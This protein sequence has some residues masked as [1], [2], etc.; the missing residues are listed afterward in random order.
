M[1]IY[2][3]IVGFTQIDDPRNAGLL[4]DA[5]ALG[6]NQLKLI[7]CKNI[8]FIEGQL[9][10]ETCK[11]LAL[12]LLIDPV[13][14]SC[15]WAELPCMQQE[16][17]PGIVMVEVALRPGVT[18]PVADEIV[19]ASHELGF[20]QVKRAASGYRYLVQGV[21]ETTARQ[22]TQRLLA[23][24]VIHRWTIGEIEPAFPGVTISSGD[25]EILRMRCADTEL[26]A[27]SKDRRA[28]LDLA[29][30]Q[31]IR[32]FCEEAKR[33][34][35]DIEF[36]T[37]AQTWSEHCGHKTFKG[38]ISVDRGDGNSIMIDSL[39]KTFIRSATEEINADWVLSAFVDNAGIIELDGENEIS[40]KVETHNHPSAIEPFGGANTGVGGVIRDVMGVSHKPIANTD[41]LCFGMQE[42]SFD[43]LPEGVLHPRRIMTGVVA[44]VQDYGNKMGIPTVNG[45]ILFDPGYA[46]NPLVFC[47]TLGMAP[48]RLHGRTPQVGDRVIVLGGRTG[49]DG[50]RGATFSSMTMDAQT[51]E[52]SGSSVQIGNPIIE[53]G[54]VDA[55]LPARDLGLYTAITDCG[56][57]GLSSAVGEMAATI[58]ADV[59][60]LNVRLKYPG[61]APWEIWLSE[62]QERMVLAVPPAN[63]TKLL[64]LC[65]TYNVE[66]TDIGFFSGSKRLVVRYNQKVVLDLPNA[67]LHDGIPQRELMAKVENRAERAENPIQAQ[68]PSVEPAE[69]LLKLLAHPNI[70]SK[71]GV[72]RLYDHE[73]QG[74]T[75]VKPLTGAQNDGPADAS[76]LKPAGVRGQAGIAIACGINPEFGKID[77]YRMAMAVVDEAVRNCVAAGADPERI[78]ILDNFCWGDP[79]H[80]ETLGGLVEACRGCRDAA[81]LFRTPFIS[82]KDSL[83]NEYLGADGN[84]HAIPP[85]LLISSVGVIRDVNQAM[86]MD[87]KSAG[88]IIYLVGNFRPVLGG[89]HFDLVTGQV[90]EEAVPKVDPNSARLYQCL[91]QAITDKRVHACHDLSEG[92]L[93]VSAAEMCMAGRLGLMIKLPE[94]ETLHCLFGETTGCLLVEVEPE[95]AAAFESALAGLPIQE[96]GRVTEGT[97]L[98][99]LDQGKSLIELPIDE[100]LA[101]WTK[102]LQPVQKP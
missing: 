30:M 3:T 19:R 60:L 89:S 10:L 63:L 39:Y 51:G 72:I 17:E 22:L 70:A 71:A 45:A 78:A 50:L 76:V 47:G 13:T 56:A 85:T 93:G 31:A 34:L 2:R 57:G 16:M 41:V 52:V 100:L 97:S 46:A 12:S 36:E 18:D 98:Q 75:V 6:F 53:K 48:K 83:N 38:K 21:D 74:G 27:I 69:I 43:E 23:N 77:T 86:T 58:G 1:P 54:L 84:R 64:E 68:M 81:L 65:D 102:P 87:L 42:T 25:V 79:L 61:L 28:A 7:Q 33:D 88:N 15:E 99:I 49:R 8:Y 5:L 59:D 62:A 29:E 24:M 90:S 11:Q 55:L 66:L 73:V 82:G 26:Q 96:L 95:Q 9:S 4:A 80:P 35:S 20:L 44:G 101:A 67:F 32:A 91:H 14:Q 94:G 92:G 37:I 40:F